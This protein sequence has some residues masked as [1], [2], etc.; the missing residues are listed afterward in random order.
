MPV[1]G[2]YMER[3]GRAMDEVLYGG[4]AASAALGRA[5]VDVSARLQSVADDLA[6]HSGGEASQSK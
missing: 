1:Q 2:Y 6:H 3:L 4:Q 5:R